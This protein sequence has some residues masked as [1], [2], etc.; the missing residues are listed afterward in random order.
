MQV[1]PLTPTSTIGGI[2]AAHPKSVKVFQ[3]LGIDFCCG[4]KRTLDEVCASSNL[5]VDDVLARIASAEQSPE[6]QSWD[7]AP[8]NDLIDHI[9]ARHHEPLCEEL[10][11]IEGMARRVLAVH[12]PKDPEGLQAM[13]DTF[14]ALRD[15]L[16]PHMEKEET[17]L[18]PWIRS[19]RGAEAQGP[20]RVMLLE[21]E[22]VGGLL[23]TLRTLTNDYKA[24]LG[25]CGTWRALWQAFED[26]EADL[27]EH[28]HLENNILF[29]RA[30]QGG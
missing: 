13:V 2:A 14:V 20:V 6:T 1:H 23:R 4:G 19:G 28:I 8:L 22:R 3:K 17:I 7:E 25:A 29:P 12:G 5:A 21:H 10:P 18:F 9:L 16:V 24:P 30:L 27:H 26:L 11:R 15:D